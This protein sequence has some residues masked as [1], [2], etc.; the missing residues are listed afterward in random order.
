[1]LAPIFDSFTP[2][3]RALIEEAIHKVPAEGLTLDVAWRSWADLQKLITLTTE[4][5]AAEIQDDIKKL[6]EFML[7]KDALEKIDLLAVV[8]SVQQYLTNSSL[9]IKYFEKNIEEFKTSFEVISKSFK[10]KI[11]SWDQKGYFSI[12]GGVCLKAAANFVFDTASIVFSILGLKGTYKGIIKVFKKIPLDKAASAIK[13]LGGKWKEASNFEKA[14]IVVEIF[15][16]FRSLFLNSLTV[17]LEGFGIE[18]IA[19]CLQIVAWT[20]SGGIAIIAQVI[21]ML[22]SLP[23]YYQTIIAVQHNCFNKKLTSI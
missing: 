15:L 4:E 23:G 14:R 19:I 16:E 5:F 7:G 3:E 21:A 20:A 17:L 9:D 18:A 6:F 13:S 1:M 12:P 8:K 10:E 2:E 22:V 11:A